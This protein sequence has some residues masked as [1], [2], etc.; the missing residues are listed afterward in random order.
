MELEQ[1]LCAELSITKEELSSFLLMAPNKYKI[2]S[3][4]KRSSGRRTIAH[5]TSL[6]KACQRCALLHL[7]LFFQVHSVAYAYK[8]GIGIK[9]NAKCHLK[10][11]YLLKMDF[12][13]FFHSIT[14]ILLFKITQKLEVDISQKDKDI[15]E[16]LLFWRPSKRSGGKLILSI[17]APSSPFISNCIL[18]LFDEELSAICKKKGIKYTR[19]ADDLTF[20]SNIKNILFDMPKLVKEQLLLHFNTSISINET[21]TIFSSKAHN[22]HVTGVTLSNNGTLSIG[23]KRKR[24]ISSLIHKYS[25]G[26]LATEDLNYL[27]G[28][29]SFAFD[30]EPEFIKRMEKKYSEKILEQLRKG[31][32]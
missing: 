11:K 6:L 22:R 24:Y 2:Y 20:S 18:Y 23:R 25:L 21:K 9:D 29:L 17:G 28:L 10:S 5:P 13:N 27:Q 14:P 16:K 26:I 8:K 12:Q 19:Y 3:I 7:E 31:L 4:P 32:T 30:I 15:L 1:F